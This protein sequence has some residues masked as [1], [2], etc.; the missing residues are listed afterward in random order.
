[1]INAFYYLY[2]ITNLTNKRK[3]IG[4]HCTYDMNDGYT[5]SSKELNKDIKKGHTV[6]VKII[7]QF[8]NIF[9]LGDA[10]F[11]MIK[12]CDAIKDKMYY[13]ENNYLKYNYYFEYG[14][15]KEHINNIS[16]NLKGKKKSP[17]TKEH[18]KK[19]GDANKGRKHSE[20]EN[21]KNRQTHLGK[22]S[23]MK[24]K[25]HNQESKKKISIGLKGKKKPVRT[26]EH[27]KHQSESMKGHIPWNKGIKQKDYIKLIA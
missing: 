21:E 11:I 17:R 26:K 20:E 27:R 1:M 16:I 24:D 12:I 25:H 7:K 5:G 9:D 4:Q 15:S 8:T 2:V 19:I 14:L 18:A 10:E 22:P 6:K 23:G 3:Y 13:N